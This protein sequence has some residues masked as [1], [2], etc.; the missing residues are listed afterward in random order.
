MSHG[1][2]CTLN[3]DGTPLGTYTSYMLD[4]SGHPL[5]RLRADA[6]HKANLLREPR[7]SLFVQPQ[8]MPAR[9]LARVTL[10]GKVSLR[11]IQAQREHSNSAR[12]ETWL[13]HGC[14][15]SLW[16]LPHP[17]RRPSCTGKW[18]VAVLE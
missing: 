5:L 18:Q 16:M 14:R 8:D 4:D 17:S 15:Q 1:T 6:V 13:Y 10:I 9:L 2:L 3:E 11:Q 12:A 7:C